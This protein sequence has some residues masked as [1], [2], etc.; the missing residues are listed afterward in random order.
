M[1]GRRSRTITADQLTSCGPAG[2][3]ASACNGISP[4]D[5]DQSLLLDLSSYFLMVLA[6]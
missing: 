6:Q 2:L 3:G 5:P 1:Y 4:P